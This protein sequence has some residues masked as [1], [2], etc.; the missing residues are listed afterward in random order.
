MQTIRLSTHGHND[1]IDITVKVKTI[2]E[3]SGVKE[4]ICLV[5]SPGSTCGVTIME[6]EEG[7]IA[8]LK[9]ALERIAP[10]SGDYL[11]SQ[12]W[13]DANGYAHI[14]AAF[15]KPSL[16]VPVKNGT[17]NLGT[18]QQIVFIDF[19]NRERIRDISVSV[20]GK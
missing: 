16:A 1:I 3:E 4:G 12:K 14:R 19:D 13:G 8:D 2:V 9:K 5:F 17:L 20:L 11:H 7:L 18:W 6:Y 15:I 10:V